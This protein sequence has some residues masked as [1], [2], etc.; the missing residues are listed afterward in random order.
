VQN[1]NEE[2]FEK[3]PNVLSYDFNIEGLKIEKVNKNELWPIQA[4]LYSVSLAFQPFIVAI[5]HG[6]NK[7]PLV[8]F[9]KDFVTEVND[10]TLNGFEY[11]C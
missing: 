5:Y 4:K 3:L 8:D 10:L 1:A 11:R 7:P 2:N 6:I 9:F